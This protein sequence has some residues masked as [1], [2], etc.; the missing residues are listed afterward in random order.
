MDKKFFNIIFSTDPTLTFDILIDL[1]LSIKKTVCL[2]VTRAKFKGNRIT[3][4][5]GD[6]A[7]NKPILIPWCSK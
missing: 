4:T 2:V 3:L 1:T 6:I 5:C 7:L